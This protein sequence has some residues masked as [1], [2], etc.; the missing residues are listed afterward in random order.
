M[1]FKRTTQAVQRCKNH[2]KR[3]T[4]LEV[5]SGTAPAA[6]EALLERDGVY[7]FLLSGPPHED[8]AAPKRLKRDPAW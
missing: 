2:R 7:E 8:G 1:Y 6:L 3:S 4:Y 5:W